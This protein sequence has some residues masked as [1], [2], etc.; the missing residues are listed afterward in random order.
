MTD[1]RPR[2]E[3]GRLAALL[4][5][6]LLAAVPGMARAQGAGLAPAPG[7][8]LAAQEAEAAQAEPR[9]RRAAPAAAAPAPVLLRVVI[10][11][12]AL[13]PR[14]TLDEIAA[15]FAGR[16][17]TGA[18]QAALLAEIDAIYAARGLALA[19]ARIDAVAGGEL[20]VALD[21]PRAGRVRA[22]GGRPS[23]AYLAWRLGFAPGTVIDTAALTEN[24]TRLSLTDGALIEAT[25]ARG[26]AAGTLD[27]GLAQ[28]PAPVNRGFVSF[29]SHGK[30]T[31][32]LYRLGVGYTFADLTGWNDPLSLHAAASRGSLSLAL[33]YRR[34]VTP[35][36]TQLT[37]GVDLARSRS[38]AAPVTQSR[39]GG[40]QIGLRHPLLLTE[41][42]QIFA[43]AA[44]LGFTETGD[45]SGAP[46]V[47]Q[48]GQG[49]RLGLSGQTGGAGWFVNAGAAVTLVRWRDGVAGGGTRTLALPS[50]QLAAVRH[51]G[52]DWAVS[53]QSAAQLDLRGGAPSRFRFGVA[54]A[55]AVR[56]HDPDAASGDRGLYARLQLERRTPVPLGAGGWQAR[57]FAFVDAGRA[58]DRRNGG[59]HARQPGLVSV[60]IGS[61][62]GLPGRFDGEVTLVRPRRAGAWQKPVLRISLST[63]F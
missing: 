56:G 12:S 24:L 6:L 35:Q 34:A 51:L 13:L 46:L 52:A 40:V 4:A 22:E 43:E 63:S 55:G 39:S 48:R 9:A 8:V 60:G 18:V 1:A 30:A 5:G 47:R 29:D 36:G 37:L 41:Q 59:G 14:A 61:S 11:P 15:R 20:R 16:R 45:I 32:G 54:G 58:W 25:F 17:A 28:G 21:E 33:G 7:A 38:R 19:Q 42:H 44:I 57:P 50:L 53:L 23:E 26:V 62:I 10:G 3:I 27:L 31:T 2:S 49:V